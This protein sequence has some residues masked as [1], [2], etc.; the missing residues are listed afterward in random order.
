MA[1]RREAIVLEDG[2]LLGDVLEGWQ[3]EDFRALDDPQHRHA[4][5]ERPR[6]HAKTFD[7]GTE[8]VTQLV[9]GPP[10]Q[11][12]Y[13]AAADEDQARLLFDDVLGKFHRAPLL[14][15]L[16]A[17][18]RRVLRVPSLGST[19]TVLASDA[20]SAFGLRPDMI[21]VDEL[22][23]W[24]GRDLWDSLWSATGKRPRSRMLCIS[25]A[26]WDKASL[27][28]EIRSIA[29]RE[30]DWLLSSRGPCASWVSDAWR[31]QQ[32]RTLPRHVFARLHLNQWIEGAGAFLTAAEVDSIFTETV[33]PLR[34][35]AVI[36]LD[37]GLTKDK[38]VLAVVRGDPQ[39]NLIAVDALITWTPGRG[40]KVDLQQVEAAVHDMARAHAAKVVL[41]PWQA[42]LLGQRLRTRGLDVTE[43]SFSGDSRRRLFATM[44]DLVRGGRL[45]CR[46]HEDFR[47]ELLGLEVQ[48]TAAGWR[49]DH[50]VGHHDDHVVAVALAAQM[51]ATREAEVGGAFPINGMTINLTGWGQPRDAFNTGALDHGA[52]DW[53]DARRRAR[54]GL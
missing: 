32:E 24:R 18:T 44:L 39:T 27:A 46:P 30:A 40:E 11:K 16:I 49:V 12:L 52:L 36:G 26:G 6:G 2:R 17:V 38:S 47:R 28:W 10:G 54:Y 41:D 20:P 23:E 9:L 5:L 25:S 42:T 21:L 50:R 45:R 51:V 43:Y 1:F 31:A 4:Y 29:E 34:G 8:A 37:L 19:L 53:E 35:P 13:C 33:P 3:E 22:A 14:A 7:L 48:E 15:P